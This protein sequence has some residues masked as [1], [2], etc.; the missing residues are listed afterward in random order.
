MGDQ[1]GVNDSPSPLEMGVTFRDNCDI[2][3]KT[4]NTNKPRIN[5][6]RLGVEGSCLPQ[7]CESGDGANTKAFSS[8]Y[9]IYLAP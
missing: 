5:P 8:R 7:G 2:G 6:D 3:C 4:I 1:R 9:S